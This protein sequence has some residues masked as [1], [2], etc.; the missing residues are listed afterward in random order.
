MVSTF[1]VFQWKYPFW[2]YLVQKNKIVSLSRNLVQRIIAICKIPLSTFSVFSLEIPFLN[3]FVPK[4]RDCQFE[5]KV[6]TYTNS[7]ME[8]SIRIPLW[9]SLVPNFKIDCLKSN[10]VPRLIRIFTIK[11]WCLHFWPEIPFLGKFSPKNQN[12]QFKLKFDT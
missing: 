8:N 11:W 3:K 2:A 10:L 9:A 7:N 4:N 5:L 6:G 12:F 1:S